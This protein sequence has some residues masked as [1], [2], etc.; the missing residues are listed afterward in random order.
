[1]LKYVFSRAGDV[2]DYLG[3]QGQKSAS[4]LTMKGKRALRGWPAILKD[5]S[6]RCAA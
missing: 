5:S 6:E 4:M 3:E 1:M 2:M